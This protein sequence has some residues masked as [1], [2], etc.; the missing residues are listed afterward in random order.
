MHRKN[1][2]KDRRLRDEWKILS[3]WVH[4]PAGCTKAYSGDRYRTSLEAPAAE[5]EWAESFLFLGGARVGNCLDRIGQEIGNEP[6]GS[7]VCRSE[8]DGY[9]KKKIAIGSLKSCLIT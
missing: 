7:G 9:R 6:C 8:R 4:K 1:Q 3:R 5:G 2:P